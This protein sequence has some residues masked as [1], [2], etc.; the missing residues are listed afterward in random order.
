MA[1]V[2]LRVASL[3]CTS[4]LA[5]A[6]FDPPP[7]G[8]D[9]TTTGVCAEG[10]IRD[11][12]CDDGSPGTQAC[13]EFAF[14]PCECDPGGGSTGPGDSTTDAPP[15]GTDDSTTGLDD[16]S[17]GEPPECVEPADCQDQVGDPECQSAD[18]VGGSCVIANADEGTACGDKT[19]SGCDRPDTCD[20]EGTCVDRQAADGSV[21]E[22]CD[23]GNCACDT[24]LCGDCPAVALS[25]GFDSPRSVANWELTGD[26]MLRGQAV[27]GLEG[28][29]IP[30]DSEV[31][32]TDG[33]RQPAFP[34]GHAE[35]SY[36]RTSPIA[37]P[38][39]IEFRSW[40]MDEGGFGTGLP[41]DNKIVRISTDGGA[42]WVDLLN[43]VEDAIIR[44]ICNARLTARDPADWDDV[45]LDVDPAL[46]GQMA[47]VEFAYETLDDCCQAERGWYIDD[48]NFGTECA[49]LSDDNCAEY[50][51][52]CMPSGVCDPA[53]SCIGM[54]A[55]VDTACGDPASSGCS[56]ADRCDALGNC[57][58]RDAATF[59]T[60]CVDCP[61]GDC[62]TCIDGTCG[63]CSTLVNDF[64]T[65]NNLD[66]WTIEALDPMLDEPGW[67]I[68]RSVPRNQFFTP[69]TNLSSIPASG[70][71]LGN[72]GNRM[73][74][75]PGG[76][77][78]HSRITTPADIF[79]GTLT[80]DSW[81][82]D[83]GGT[84]G[85][86][87]DN[88]IIEYTVNGGVTWEVIVDCNTVPDFVA[89]PFCETLTTSREIDDWDAVSI[90]MGVAAG[91][92]GQLRLTYN[93]TDS[94]CGGERGWFIDNLNFAQ[95]CD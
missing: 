47:L 21:C 74:P 37:L 42:T 55:P 86:A 19:T 8:S 30:F 75:Y 43:C 69:G 76:H 24:G 15:P 12:T 88:K 73:P 60:E 38:P 26:W 80:F 33:N 87:Y 4:L 18:C 27:A 9:D 25:N 66:G 50:A 40:H 49:C 92:L 65:P 68:Y 62:T 17:T 59:I 72:D 94:C 1:V 13:G 78:E 58:V 63:D 84:S 57:N 6:C 3:A 85:S 82:N 70:A 23:S 79:P 7:P 61:S 39:T 91:A 89:F 53:G 95:P 93:S 71:V 44:P 54:P 14:G 28:P 46:V 10:E 36:A 34:G 52:E 83:E 5:V 31:L 56:S 11:C 41:Y 45:T 51:T 20:G 35:S 22:G 2:N 90:D 16:S 29:A 77:L 81:H 64:A 67:G 48:L 32:G